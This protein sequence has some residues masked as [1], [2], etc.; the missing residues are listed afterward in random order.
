MKLLHTSDLHGSQEKYG[1]LLKFAIQNK[2]DIID[3]TGDCLPG[4]DPLIIRQRAFCLWLHEWMKQVAHNGI[5]LV[6]V[7]G[8]DDLLFTDK[9]IQK[10][11]QDDPL[12]HWVDGHTTTI[13]G[14]TFVGMSCVKDLPYGLKDR[15][16]LD[17]KQDNPLNIS[18]PPKAYLTRWREHGEDQV[19]WQEIPVE[20][21]IDRIKGLPALS[22]ILQRLPVNKWDTTILM[23]HDPPYG[24]GLDVTHSD[25]QV[26]SKAVF[27]FIADVQPYITVHGH[28]HE[29]P[30]RSGVWQVEIGKSLCIQVGQPWT[31]L[32]VALIHLDT[33]DIEMVKTQLRR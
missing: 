21:W 17:Y 2:V 30:S 24:V 15:A 20:E 19:A 16:R 23:T 14:Y 26:G 1:K 5:H 13:G 28:I 25:E 22:E 33:R 3:L 7:P 27:D 18:Q 8:N 11:M 12:L 6:Y 10:Y 4:R 32:N 29:S 9:L 31:H